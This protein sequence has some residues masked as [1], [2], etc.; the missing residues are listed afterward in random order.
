MPHEELPYWHFN[1]PLQER[2]AECPD[3]LLNIDDKD[4]RMIGSWESN[5]EAKSWDEVNKL[6]RTS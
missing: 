3:Y 2:T 4:K 1:V 6:I 5:Y